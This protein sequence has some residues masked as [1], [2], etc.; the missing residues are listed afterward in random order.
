[1]AQT[2]TYA[3]ACDVVLKVD[4]SAGVLTDITGSSSQASLSL[5]RTLGSLVT[6]EGEWD[7]VLGCKI[8]GTISVTAVYSTA[9]TEARNILEGWIFNDDG[10]TRLRTVQINVPDDSAGSR[11]YSGEAVIESY[12]LPLDASSADPIAVTAQL[13][14]SGNW[15]RSVISS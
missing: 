5:T 9:N 15:V 12:E 2:T 14:T 1:M 8:S 13:R 10:G 4:N 11:R 6:F 3:N 7:I